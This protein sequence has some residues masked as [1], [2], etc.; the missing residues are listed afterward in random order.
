MGL[1]LAGK[2]LGGYRVGDVLESGPAGVLYAAEHSGS[3]DKVALKVYASDLA[4]DKSLAARVVADVQR[5]VAVTHPNLAPVREVGTAEF[6]GKR[7]LFVAMERLP[8]ESLKSLL[9]KQKGQ[10]LPVSRALHIGSE[11]A[12]ALEAIHRGNQVHRQLNAA[13]VFVAP[14]D[15]DRD[16]ER[17][18]VLDLGAA[19][20]PAGDDKKAKAGG[21]VQDDLRSLAQLLYSMLGGGDSATDNS[22]AVLPLRLRNHAVPARIDAV[23]R[24]VLSDVLGGGDKAARYDSAAAFIAALLG[25]GETQPSYGRW[26]E[27]GRTPPP[28]RKSGGTLLWAGIVAVAGGLALGYFLFPSDTSTPGKG[29]ANGQPTIPVV[30]RA[31]PNPSSSAASD[32][33]VDAAPAVRA[34]GPGN[35]PTRTGGTIPD[36]RPADEWPAKPSPLPSPV[37]APGAAATAGTAAT[38]GA[39]AA[40]PQAKPTATPGG[41]P[42]ANPPPG[43]TAPVGVTAPKALPTAPATVPAAPGTAG[44]TVPPPASA[45][46]PAAPTT[47]NVAAPGAAPVVNKPAIPSPATG[48]AA[49]PLA[50]PA[51]TSGTTTANPTTPAAKP[52]IPAM[53][54]VGTTPAGKPAVAPAGS[55]LINPAAKPTATAPAGTAVPG[56]ASTATANKPVAGSAP[57]SAVAPAAKAP[58]TGAPATPAAP[59]ARPATAPTAAPGTVAAKPAAAGSTSPPAPGVSSGVPRSPS[60]PAAPA[61]AVPAAKNPEPRP[62]SPGSS[63]PAAKPAA[64]P[65]G[66]HGPQ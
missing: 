22:Q 5:A 36:V 11:I 56:A 54:P 14:G 16:E 10:P 44:G 21:K 31:N 62:S 39:P 65:S 38:P 43:G 23:L 45:A 53:N 40:V 30:D 12:A 61:G 4:R 28:A 55:A 24:S 6:K 27:D 8:G 34:P 32:A 42:A 20:I 18:V 57:G 2:T 33:G 9:N 46:K 15:G 51:A 48:G 37:A 1:E 66:A 47:P 25:S 17:V 64:S 13:A 52:A 60:A 19:A 59:T 50:K 3:G 7:H 41:T 58:A 63:A 49:A 35:W 29:P 26:S